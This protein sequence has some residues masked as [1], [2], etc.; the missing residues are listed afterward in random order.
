MAPDHKACLSTYRR[1]NYPLV[2][3]Y[4]LVYLELG[5]LIMVLV[6]SYSRD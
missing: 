4:I 2:A 6:R 1:P 5:W 3:C